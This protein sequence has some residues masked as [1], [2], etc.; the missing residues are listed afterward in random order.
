[1]LKMITT[2]QINDLAERIR[3]QFQPEKIVLFGSHAYGTPTPYSDVDLLVVMPYVGGNGIDQ[4]VRIIRAVSPQFG[5]DIVVRR[6]DDL[7]Q[8]LA[9]GDYF[10]RDIVSKGKVLYDADNTGMG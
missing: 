7:R 5:L 8:R 4:A 10:L 9:D 2:E 6:P 3:H 1:M